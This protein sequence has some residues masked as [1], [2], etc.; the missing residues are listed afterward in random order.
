V[1]YKAIALSILTALILFALIFV[2]IK[3]TPKSSGRKRA[4]FIVTA[5]AL[6][7]VALFAVYADCKDATAFRPKI[8]INPRKGGTASIVESVGATFAVFA[9]ASDGYVFTGWSGAS[10]LTINPLIFTLSGD[11]RLTANF[12]RYEPRTV[13]I[14]NRRWMAENLNVVVGNSWCY[15]N[16]ESNC[17]KYGRLYDYRT[18]ME[19]CPAGWRLPTKDDWNS[20]I[21]AG[22][23]NA[24]KKLKSK[25]GWA[26]RECHTYDD[27]L[28]EGDFNFT[29]KTDCPENMS[30]NGTDEFGFSALPGGEGQE[31]D[32]NYVG[33]V[34]QWWTNS[35]YEWYQLDWDRDDLED[36][37]CIGCGGEEGKSIRCVQDIP[38]VTEKIVSF[39]DPPPPIVKSWE[40]GATT[41]TYY[42]NGL[43][44]VSGNGEMEGCDPPWV[45]YSRYPSRKYC[46][47]PW[48]F[49]PVAGLIIDDGVTH[50]GSHA[51][52]G[53]YAMSYVTIP[54]SVVF[55]GRKAF[56]YCIS[57]RSI[58]IRNPSP[59]E[60]DGKIRNSLQSPVIVSADEVFEKYHEDI[61]N[62]ACLYVPE[63]SINA[64]RAAEG[65]KEFGCIKGLESAPKG[66]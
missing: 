60:I 5:V 56:R 14:G 20:L 8:K 47:S 9:K 11:K 48:R 43:L 7:A 66:I 53:C 64:Y 39:D 57:L 41:V 12:K 26:D 27:I 34:A 65:W 17:R 42:A 46:N 24:G 63:N 61:M 23:Y 51:F 22:G 29:K 28:D 32:F 36:A 6:S 49:Y 15:D 19:A 58:I 31:N 1:Y 21:R 38:G 30:G 4:A 3:K 62:E 59:P 44:R 45:E 2:I 50:I 54:S 33:K 16:D 25:N 35:N 37:R 10:N 40:S 55:I 18:A 52:N 13:Q